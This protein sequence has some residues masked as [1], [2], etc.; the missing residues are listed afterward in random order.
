MFISLGLG[1]WV[2]I[3]LEFDT[4]YKNG[5]ALV[6]LGKHGE[7]VASFDKAL[8]INPNNMKTL[9]NK[10][11]A[12]ARLGKHEEAVASFDK[13]L[14]INPNELDVLFNKDLVLAKLNQKKNHIYLEMNEN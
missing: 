7:A 9:S 2:Q 8:E 10:G 1:D 12:L 11:V 6:R 4:F 13:A 5:I 3:N 14:E